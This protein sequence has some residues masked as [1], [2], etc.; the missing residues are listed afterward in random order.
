MEY[1]GHVS[2]GYDQV[3]VR[4]DLQARQFIAFWLKGGQVKAGMNVNIWDVTDSVKA[5]IRSGQQVSP[6]ALADPGT[7][8]GDLIPG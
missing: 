5:L 1:V 8:L 6:E 7:A 3:V 2:G 4:G